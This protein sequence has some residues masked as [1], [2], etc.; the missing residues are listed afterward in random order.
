MPRNTRALASLN[1]IYDIS[2]SDLKEIMYIINY[3]YQ[4][5]QIK[6]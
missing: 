4:F 6:H 1:G 2:S 3:N 5:N